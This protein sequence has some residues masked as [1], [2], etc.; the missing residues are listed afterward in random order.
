MV[1]DGATAAGVVAA[2]MVVGGITERQLRGWSD[3]YEL[4]EIIMPADFE[5]VSET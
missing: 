1:V 5:T 4:L 2:G 3:D